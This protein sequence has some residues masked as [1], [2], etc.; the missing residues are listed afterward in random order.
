MS[1]DVD[2]TEDGPED[3]PED[4]AECDS[5]APGGRYS[6]KRSEWVPERAN[7]ISSAT[8]R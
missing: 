2:G 4:A 5:D 8:T 7:V 3:G 1:D 6:S